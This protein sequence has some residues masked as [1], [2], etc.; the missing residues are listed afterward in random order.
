MCVFV[1]FVSFCRSV[2]RSVCMSLSVCLS[3]CPSVG[4]SVCLSVCL[5]ATLL[6]GTSASDASIYCT[7]YNSFIDLF[8]GRQALA[9]PLPGRR[10][11]ALR[12]GGYT[13]G[14]S[15]AY[16]KQLGSRVFSG[17]RGKQV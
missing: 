3:V 7:L 11:Y 5:S 8:G 13:F 2:G 15:G 4:R 6:W 9:G 12:R 10:P 17:R 14:I 1:F 16:A